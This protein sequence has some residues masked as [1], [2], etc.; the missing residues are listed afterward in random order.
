[1]ALIEGAVA[2]PTRGARAV[3]A[4]A[5]PCFLHNL[6]AVALHDPQAVV[7]MAAPQV[8]GHSGPVEPVRREGALDEAAPCPSSEKVQNYAAV[9]DLPDLQEVG[10]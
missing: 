7:D 4:P 10:R 3:V 2:L 6:Q 8:S 5:A 9:S 1:M